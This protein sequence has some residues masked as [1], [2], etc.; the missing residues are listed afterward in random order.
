MTN[1]PSRSR[2]EVLLFIVTAPLVMTS[3]T[4]TRRTFL[5]SQSRWRRVFSIL[6]RVAVKRNIL[7]LDGEVSQRALYTIPIKLT[8]QALAPGVEFMLLRICLLF[9]VAASLVCVPSA[10]FA[11]DKADPAVKPKVSKSDREGMMKSLSNWGRWGA[12]DELGTLNLI[13][14]EKRLVAAKQRK[15]WDFLITASSL[16]VPGATGS[17]LNPIAIF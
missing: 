7:P 12:A 6:L 9:S 3:S 14:P 13:T 5:R 8:P 4:A 11:A 16:A 1:M 15:R 2:S 10:P 17:A